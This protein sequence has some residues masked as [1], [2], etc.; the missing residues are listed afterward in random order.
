MG[1]AKTASSGG[2]GPRATWNLPEVVY[3]YR[4]P[5]CASLRVKEISAFL[6]RVLGLRSNVRDEFFVHHQGKD[7]ED[8][9]RRLAATRV[10]DITRPIQAHE[11]LFGEI[12]FERNLL[13]DPKKRVPA[14]LYDAFEYLNLAKSLLP[15]EESSLRTLH[16]AFIHRLIGTFGDDGRYH[17]RTVVCGFPCV[18]STSGL[19][20]APA[21]PAGYYKLKAELALA[22]GGVPFEAAK[23]PFEGQF[24]DYDD[25]R[26]TE[27]AK[28]YALQAAMYHIAKEAFCDDPRCRLFDAHT[29]SELLAAQIAS[30]KLCTDHAELAKRI[31]RLMMNKTPKQ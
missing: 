12:Q 10:R 18:V 1:A 9:A 13:F 20:E 28:G 29:Q 31:R 26:M 19:V 23:A 8:F 25:E 4:D 11:P 15:R 14:I 22:V 7:P 24:L 17:A 30:G 21:K 16:L 5:S 6:G 27:V 3:L 2:E